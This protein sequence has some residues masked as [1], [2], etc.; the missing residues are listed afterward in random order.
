MVKK[1][2]EVKGA[3]EQQKNTTNQAVLF[4]LENLAIKGRQLVYDV[5]KKA[6]ADNDIALTLNMFSRYCSQPSVKQFIPVMLKM[7]PKA[8]V[9]EA[10]LIPEISEAIN[11]VFLAGS[12]KLESGLTRML[13]VMQDQNVMVAALS[14]LS[15]ETARQLSAKLGLVAMVIRRNIKIEKK[16][17]AAM[18]TGKT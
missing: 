18:N 11:N 7:A 9:S 16:N 5:L 3:V 12:L 6:L 2:I 8:K 13:K 4:E 1:K 14:S 10:K 15:D 17:L